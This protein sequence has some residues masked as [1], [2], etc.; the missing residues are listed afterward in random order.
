VRERRIHLLQSQKLVQKR[1]S[2]GRKNQNEKN[3]DGKKEEKPPDVQAEDKM[4]D[5]ATPPP[6]PLVQPPIQELSTM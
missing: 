6:P 2:Q 5:K 1:K 3:A 4:L